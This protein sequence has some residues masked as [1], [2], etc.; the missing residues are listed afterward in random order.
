[1]SAFK[2]LDT[3][4]EIFFS[5]LN[6]FIISLCFSLRLLRNILRLVS[7]LLLLVWL[8]GWLLKRR[9][10]DRLIVLGLRLIARLLVLRL[11]LVLWLLVII[12]WLILWLLI[13]WL[14]SWNIMLFRLH[15]SGRL[16]WIVILLIIRILLLFPPLLLVIVLFNRHNLF[17][18]LC[19]FRFVW[20]ATWR[21]FT[22][23]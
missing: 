22:R 21:N 8:I 17:L 7:K 6:C 12:M 11:R 14:R 19:F 10:G 3:L 1:M 16:I 20:I 2:F 18:I 23:F 4:S 5:V 13:L 9:L 15:R